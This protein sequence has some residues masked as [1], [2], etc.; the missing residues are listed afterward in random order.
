M[1]LSTTHQPALNSRPH[2][3][4][5]KPAQALTCAETA[6]HGHHTS[7]PQSKITCKRC[8]DLCLLELLPSRPTLLHALRARQI[9]QVQHTRHRR[10]CTGNQQRCT[11]HMM[12][13]L[14][15][16]GRCESDVIV[17][18]SNGNDTTPGSYQHAHKACSRAHWCCGGYQF[19][20]LA[21]CPCWRSTSRQRIHW[22]AIQHNEST[23]PVLELLP[24]ILRLNTMWEREECSLSCVH[25]TL[26]LSMASASSPSTCRN[27][28]FAVSQSPACN[29]STG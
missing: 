10:A 4:C 25:P 5:T 16:C 22:A 7:V 1:Q 6:G 9:N 14:P 8:T 29:V 3:P 2:F 23:P 11:G 19:W 28:Y 18:G 20:V 27:I 26:R 12:L 21:A 15:V 17:D 24:S 13:V